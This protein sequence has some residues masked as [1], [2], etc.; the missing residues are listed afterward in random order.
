MASRLTTFRIAKKNI[1]RKPQRSFCLVLMIMLF[2]F[3][4]FAGAVLSISLSNGVSSM[5]DRLGAD[6]IVVPEG[7]DPHID[8]I[9]LSG[10]PSTF[11]LPADVLDRIRE[12]GV[13]GIDKMTPQTFLATLNASCCSY[14]VQLVGID[15]D[16]DFLIKPW[17]DKTI[18]RKLKR[19]EVILGYHV[20]GALGDDIMFFKNHHDV[21]GRLEQTG[22]GFDATVFM[23]RETIADLAVAAERIIQ[24]PLAEDG[25]LIS[26]VMIKLA[27]GYN[28]VKVAK[29]INKKLN[30]QGI[31][32]LFSKKFV[33]E[34]SS[35]LTVVSGL[36]K[37]I[38]VIVW[39]LA[40]VVIALLFAMTLGERKKEM[41]ILRVMGATKGKLVRLALAEVLLISLYGSVLGVLLAGATVAVTGPMVVA[42]LSIPFLLPSIVDLLALGGIS[43]LVAVI[44]SILSAAGSAIKAGY[45]DIYDN[46]RG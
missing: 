24:H 21:A 25:S 22:M 11:Y 39:I 45:A 26:T 43:V 19:G 8:S 40:V 4:L 30:D 34:I 27:P 41:G 12:I 1:R 42:L 6:I 18:H 17:L 16:T 14:P 44:T 7:Y 2:A 38:I 33:N 10:K 46:V 13:E 35:N 32:A 36:I 15:Y 29:E 23:T 31:Y 20:A 37:I 3:S 5:S 28:S 9:L